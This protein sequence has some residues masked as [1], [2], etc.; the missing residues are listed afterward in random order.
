MDYAG[1][2]KRLKILRESQRLTKENL[3][4][5]SHI[6]RPYLSQLESG[7]A[8][9]LSKPMLESLCCTLQTTQNYLY[10]NKGWANHPQ[11]KTAGLLHLVDQIKSN[12]LSAIIIKYGNKLLGGLHGVLIKKPTYIY[13]LN[14]AVTDT[15]RFEVDP[16]DYLKALNQ[17]IYSDTLI[18]LKD[19]KVKT[20][21]IW[22]TQMQSDNIDNFNLEDYIDAAKFDNDIFE[23][24]LLQS[25]EQTVSSQQKF[26]ISVNEEILLTKIRKTNFDIYELM[27]YIDSPK[28]YN[29]LDDF[30]K[31]MNQTEMKELIKK[32]EKIINFQNSLEK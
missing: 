14:L 7:I 28:T 6:S 29:T 27:K 1:F 17:S 2:G 22:F 19:M 5:L 30:I 16:T 23:K 13:S 20:G 18:I 12:T 25:I 9:K 3:A 10:E 21:F 32:L 24:E 26:K 11:D 8:S 15:K 4:M 31:N